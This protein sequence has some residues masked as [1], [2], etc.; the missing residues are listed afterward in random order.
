MSLAEKYGTQIDEIMATYREEYEKSSQEWVDFLETLRAPTNMA[1]CVEY[2]YYE[3]EE[4][5]YDYYGY[6]QCYTTYNS[7][8]AQESRV[9][10]AWEAFVE[11]VKDSAVS[12][13][14]DED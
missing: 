14:Y 4:C 6:Y 2:D 9:G 10:L 12:N 3:T 13:G 8:C 1:R 7:Y 5:Y 11:G